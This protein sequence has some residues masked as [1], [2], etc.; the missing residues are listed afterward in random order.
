[1]LVLRQLGTKIDQPLQISRGHQSMRPKGDCLHPELV[2]GLGMTRNR[3][4]EAEFIAW[5]Q[6]KKKKKVE[7]HISW[8]Q[9]RLS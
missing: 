5:R 9:V 2:S 7:I 4:Q 3:R 6:K 1:M 8:F